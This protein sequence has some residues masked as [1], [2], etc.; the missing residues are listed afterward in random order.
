MEVRFE[1]VGIRWLDANTAKVAFDILIGAE[2]IRVYG[3]TLVK[4]GDGRRFNLYMPL[5]RK[6]AAVDL[7]DEL[8]ARLKGVVVVAARADL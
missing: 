7:S 8:Y 4:H 1:V 6:S 2:S 5:Y 3:A